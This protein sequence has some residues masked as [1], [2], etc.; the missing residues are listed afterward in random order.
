MGHMSHPST[1]PAVTFPWAIRPSGT[2]AWEVVAGT[3]CVA[4][5]PSGELAARIADEHN[6]LRGVDALR[7]VEAEREPAEADAAWGRIAQALGLGRAEET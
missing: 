7:E 5:T 1:P 2:D 4:V 3:E 6:Y